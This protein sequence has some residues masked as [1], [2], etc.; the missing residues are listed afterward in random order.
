MLFKKLSPG[1]V[2][3]SELHSYALMGGS[4]GRVDSCEM[5]STARGYGERGGFSFTYIPIDGDSGF[6]RVLLK[7]PHIQFLSLGP[8]SMGG[9]STSV[10]EKYTD[11]E[12]QFL[13]ILKET[14]KSNFLYRLVS[15][16]IKKA[17][18]EFSHNGRRWFGWQESEVP[19]MDGA[20]WR[21]PE[22]AREL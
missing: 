22:A 15:S 9:L 20:V 3:R 1:G 11:Q 14:Y 12:T 2:L 13:D 17:G 19:S 8:H 4:L 5:I 10:N 16:A 7:S 18:S 21:R 6:G